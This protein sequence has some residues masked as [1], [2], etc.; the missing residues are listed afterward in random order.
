[1]MKDL[2]A[3]L[4]ILAMLEGISL[5]LLLFIAMPLKYYQ[6]MPEF[7]SV[8]GMLHGIL[9]LALLVFSSM[10]SQKKQ[11]S[12]RFWLLVVVSSMVPFATF[13]MDR[14]LKHLQENPA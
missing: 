11:W 2:V 9:F 4:R 12:D 6:D 13:V 1:M 7:V 3:N 10:V 5:L 8:A 14:K